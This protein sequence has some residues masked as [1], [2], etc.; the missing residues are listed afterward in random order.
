M[1]TVEKHLVEGGNVPAGATFQE[2][3]A[4]VLGVELDS[5]QVSGN[6]PSRGDD[7]DNS[8]VGVLLPGRVIRVVKAR[9]I[10]G[11]T[12]GVCA[13]GQVVKPLVGCVG[14]ESGGGKARAVGR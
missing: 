1:E 12:D 11:A 9:R 14:R 7:H 4:D 5:V 3:V 10:G 2:A 6:P 8:R 13:A